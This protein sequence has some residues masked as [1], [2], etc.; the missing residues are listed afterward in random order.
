MYC[1]TPPNMCICRYSLCA[2]NGLARPNSQSTTMI[3]TQSPLILLLFRLLEEKK[4]QVIALI[5]FAG[6]LHGLLVVLINVAS[7]SLSKGAVATFPYFA[8]FLLCIGGYTYM[9]RMASRVVIERMGGWI[10][11]TQKRVAGQL[12]EASL[13]DVERMEKT[14]VY[15]SLIENTDLLMDT[16]RLLVMAGSGL[17]MVV[18]SMAFIFTISR[19]AFV[20]TVVI[21]SGAAYLYSRKQG[22]I[23]EYT[24]RLKKMESRFLEFLNHILLGLKELKVHRGRRDDLFNRHMTWVNRAAKRTKVTAERL[25]VENA[26]F[27]ETFLLVLI[28]S[29]VFLLPRFS[30]MDTDT[31]LILSMAI[32]YA[33]GPLG[34]VISAVPMLYKAD[35][36]VRDIGELGDTLEA[37]NEAKDFDPYNRLAKKDGEFASITLEDAFFTY[38]AVSSNSHGFSLGPMNFTLNKGELIFLVGGNGSGK[39]TFLK[40]LT[41]LYAPGKGRILVDNTPVDSANRDSYRELFSVLFADF[42]LFDR[43]YGLRGADKDAVDDL[44]EKMDIADKTGIRHGRFTT[45]DLSSGQ[46]KRLALTVC[47]LEDKPVY[48]LD[49]VAADLD[50]VFRKHFYETVL[51]ELKA[52]GKT[53]VAVSHDD[54]YYHVADR[55]VKMDYGSIET[56]TVPHAGGAKGHDAA[57]DGGHA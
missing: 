45:L 57:E 13:N 48:I 30:V 49:E 47:L 14:R 33:L 52:K 20:V 10:Y 56:I 24:T 28:A 35:W 16:T 17:V 37:Y 42:H 41:G 50:P 54:R 43:L 51:P 55:V 23:N 5:G 25:T 18:V 1:T 32:L 21:T 2:F 6:F 15:K 9:L 4:S 36:A 38:P 34:Q 53:I 8:M 39:S 31:V 40:L 27:A 7:E 26:I 19:S 44:L 46:K 12:M 22:V 3:P 11:K 29:V